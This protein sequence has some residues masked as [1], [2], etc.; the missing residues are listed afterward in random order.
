MEVAC[1]SETVKNHSKVTIQTNR[2]FLPE[3]RAR[4]IS[5]LK[6][7]LWIEFPGNNSLA[8]QA[9]TELGTGHETDSCVIYYALIKPSSHQIIFN[10][11][12]RKL[13]RPVMRFLL[14]F[15]GLIGLGRETKRTKSVQRPV[16]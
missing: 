3:N 13:K 7:L 11:Y 4:H 16:C 9:Y 2:S 15:V 5:F 1:S 8:S 12:S 14:F 10:L 6:T